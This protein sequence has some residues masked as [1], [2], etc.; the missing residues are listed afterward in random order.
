MYREPSKEETRRDTLLRLA[1][2]W[3]AIASFGLCVATPFAAAQTST[4]SSTY[5]SAGSARGP[6]ISRADIDVFIRVLELGDGERGVLEDLYIAYFEEWH[7]GH[8]AM[9]AEAAEL[10]EEAEI[11]QN[12]QPLSEIRGLQQAWSADAERLEKRF[13]DDVTTMLTA[14]QEG[15]WPIVERELRRIK[16]MGDSRLAGESI[17]VIR[18]VGR[19]LPERELPERIADLL[20]QYAEQLDAVLVRRNRLLEEHRPDYSALVKEDTDRAEEVY[21]RAVRARVAVCEV[22][23]RF[24]RQIAAE[25][26][27]AQA[28]QLLDA[29][30]EAAYSMYIKPTR[31][32]RQILAAENASGVS[33]E[34]ADQVA[35]LIARYRDE[36]KFKKKKLILRK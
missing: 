22:N 21:F 15:R 1:L 31:L 14:E 18:L 25:L 16:T 3:I 28:R 33:G 6:Q 4:M 10:I 35:T 30:E 26:P 8:R 34:R 29:F 36:R 13:L 11:F 27:E 32:E 2:S 17:D 23:E 5:F 12:Q 24:A 9:R 20:E 19:V 7:A